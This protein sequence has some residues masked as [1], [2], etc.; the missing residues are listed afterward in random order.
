MDTVWEEIRQSLA[1]MEEYLCFLINRMKDSLKGP[2]LLDVANLEIQESDYTRLYRRW[3]DRVANRFCRRGNSPG[4]FTI[5][6]KSYFYFLAA[7]R[8]AKGPLI[9]TPIWEAIRAN[10][11]SSLGQL[12][13]L[14]KS[15][16]EYNRAWT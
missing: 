15:I 13:Y 6:N 11:G 16:I 5:P 3:D 7:E 10:P 14:S 2:D 9:D 8:E 4:V 1:S 12:L